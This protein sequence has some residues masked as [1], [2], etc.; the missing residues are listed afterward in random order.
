MLVVKFNLIIPSNKELT[1]ITNHRLSHLPLKKKKIS[2]YDFSVFSPS[3][4]K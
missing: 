1:K 2:M 4:C 3:T